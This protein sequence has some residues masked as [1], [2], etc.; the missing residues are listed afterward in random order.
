MTQGADYVEQDVRAYEQQLKEK[1]QKYLQ[2]LALKHGL[3]VVEIQY[4][5]L[6]VTGT[7]EES[8]LIAGGRFFLPALLPSAIEIS[9][10]G[11]APNLTVPVINFVPTAV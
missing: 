11:I 5:T 10:S 8:V 2:K 7:K 3:K 9:I 4:L 1:E 6:Y